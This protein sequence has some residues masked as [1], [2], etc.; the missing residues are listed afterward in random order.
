MMGGL[1]GYS[2]SASA[3]KVPCTEFLNYM[4]TTAAQKAYY[5]AFDTIPVN[6][7]AQSVVTESYLVS[8]KNAYSKAPFVSQYLDTLYGQN[9]GNALNTGVVDL[10]AG[11][12]SVADIIK[13]T[14][15]AAAKG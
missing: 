13:N 6:K 11:T 7:N 8:V 14:N 12:G 3:P 5:K 15:L 9:V 1:D 4:V 2:C 10:L